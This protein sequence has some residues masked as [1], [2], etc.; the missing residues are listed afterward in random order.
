MTINTKQQLKITLNGF[1]GYQ[2]H[3]V[4]ATVTPAQGW[5]RGCGVP[6]GETV[7]GYNIQLTKS[8]AHK[9][10]CTSADCICGEGVPESFWIAKDKFGKKIE[11]KGHYPQNS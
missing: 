8:G 4:L 5:K 7:E 1:H 11:V 10:A 9:F 3:N 6:M 2:T